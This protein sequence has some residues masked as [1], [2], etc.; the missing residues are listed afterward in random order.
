MASGEYITFEN[1]DISLNSK[2]DSDW[3][4]GLNITITVNTVSYILQTFS[5]CLTLHRKKKA[6]INVLECH[7]INYKI[8]NTYLQY[9]GLIYI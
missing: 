5:I 6:V 9:V 7:Y 4:F 3:K 1:N 8:N 2:N